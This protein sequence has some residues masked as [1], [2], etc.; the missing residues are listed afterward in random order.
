M[1]GAVRKIAD[2]GLTQVTAI[3]TGEAET[4]ALREQPRL[5]ARPAV[6]PAQHAERLDR[7]KALLVEGKYHREIQEELGIARSTLCDLLKANGLHRNLMPKSADRI[8]AVVAL[9]ELGKSYAEC[10]KILGKTKGAISGILSRHGMTKTTPFRGVSRF[11]PARDAVVREA[12]LAG[13]PI[14]AICAKC[15]AL[16]GN[17]VSKR[18]VSNRANAMRLRRLEGY[19]P[20]SW[21]A[22]RTLPVPATARLPKATRPRSLSPTRELPDDPP[23]NDWCPGGA[24]IPVTREWSDIRTIALNEGFLLLNVYDLPGYNKSRMKRNLAPYAV[25]RHIVTN[26][27]R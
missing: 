18:N 25:P 11:G 23:S 17:P 12:F 6:T 21:A 2:G 5:R 14:S 9:R 1:H 27:W 15:N 20:E 10:A 22:P 24:R 7:L 26:K 16:P 13:E 8:N 4:C 3:A 19:K